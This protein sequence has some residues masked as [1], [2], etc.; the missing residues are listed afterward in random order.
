M[1]IQI[2]C[3]HVNSVQ[4]CWTHVSARKGMM[5]K[6]WVLLKEGG[7]GLA[8]SLHPNLLPFISKL[9]AEVTQPDL[10][11]SRTFLSSVIQG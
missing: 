10:E 4:N 6:L 1:V 11:F 7:R 3:H 5:P 8:T 9:P 2:H